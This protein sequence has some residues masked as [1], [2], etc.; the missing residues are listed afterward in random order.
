MTG[1]RFTTTISLVIAGGLFLVS[2]ISYLTFDWSASHS[3]ALREFGE[4]F[5][6]PTFSSMAYPIHVADWI[7]FGLNVFLLAASRPFRVTGRSALLSIAIVL[8]IA[9]IILS[10]PLAFGRLYGCYG[11]S[12]IIC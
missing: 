1:S 7:G 3:P 12:G 11:E 5:L 10:G 9:S 8:S 6:E 4:H 2:L